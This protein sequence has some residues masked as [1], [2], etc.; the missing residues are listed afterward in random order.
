M[1][2]FTQITLRARSIS[3]DAWDLNVEA[4]PFENQGFIIDARRQC[5]TAYDEALK[6]ETS[7]NALLH[8]RIASDLESQWGTAS[9]ALRVI[10]DFF[11]TNP[12]EMG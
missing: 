3:S 2:L 8:L 12:V 10:I 7:I 11:E 4:T 9:E 5:L 6:S 1:D